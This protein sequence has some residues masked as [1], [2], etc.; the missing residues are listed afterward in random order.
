[1]CPICIINPIHGHQ[2]RFV[3]L[4]DHL[5]REH[6]NEDLTINHKVKNLLN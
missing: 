2:I 3:S 6:D 5:A 4:A 1:M